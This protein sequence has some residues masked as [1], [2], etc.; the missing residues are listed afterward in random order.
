MRSEKLKK[1]DVLMQFEEALWHI[2]E[3]NGI[4]FEKLDHREVLP[5]ATFLKRSG[6]FQH[7]IGHHW[8]VIKEAALLVV[9][10]T[11]IWYQRTRSAS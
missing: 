7:R 8:P 9:E 5:K 3:T 11:V 4:T 6:D 10:I 2:V 1:P